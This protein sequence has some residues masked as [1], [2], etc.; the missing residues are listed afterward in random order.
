MSLTVADGALVAALCLLGAAI[1]GD[2]RRREIPDWSVLG[3]VALFFLVQLCRGRWEAIGEGTLVA[4][5]VFGAG[6]AF[7]RFGLLGGGDVKLMS[8]LALWAGPSGILQF[9]LLTSFAGGPL[10]LACLAAWFWRRR[11]RRLRVFPRVEVPYG[12]A[13]ALGAVP[14]ILAAR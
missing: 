6:V 8:A 3:L 7:F 10:S 2:L 5:A 1:H 12:V 13:I 14:T 11:H 9:M 4:V